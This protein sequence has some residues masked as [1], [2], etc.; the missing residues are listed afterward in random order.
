M[1]KVSFRARRAV[2]SSTG[3]STAGRAQ[4]AHQASAELDALTG[5]T[6][7]TCNRCAAVRPL[8]GSSA[9]AA[10]RTF[11]C[12]VVNVA[13]GMLGSGITALEIQEAEKRRGRENSRMR[14]LRQ[15]LSGT[16]RPVS[17]QLP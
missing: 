5:E 14:R 3:R 10:A 13:A 17:M 12:V 15:R 1:P 8:R 11:T 16:Q 9:S 2:S 6:Y 4:L 7:R